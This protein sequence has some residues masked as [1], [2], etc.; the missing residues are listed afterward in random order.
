MNPKIKVVAFDVDGTLLSHSLNDV[1][2]STRRAINKLQKRGILTVVVTGRHM[3]EFRNLPV[4]NIHF[5]AYLMLNGQLLLDSERKFCSGTP[6]DKDELEIIAHIF[7]ARHIPFVLIGEEDRYINYVDDTVI[8]TQEMTKGT[9]PEEGEYKGEEIYQVLAFV[10]KRQQDLLNNLLDE[11]AVTQWNDTGIDIIPKDGGKLPGLKNFL[12]EHNLTLSEAMAFGDGDNDLDMIR[13]A[14]IGVAMGNAIDKV[15][16]AADYVTDTVDNDGI[17][18]A[19]RH[20][21]L[22]D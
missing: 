14:G 6:I 11:C 21:G 22:I 3:S 1:P 12:K 20:F 5:D 19:L 15:K 13:S 16:E 2:E 9:V 10:P 8:K 4:G 7:Q 17:E 18:K